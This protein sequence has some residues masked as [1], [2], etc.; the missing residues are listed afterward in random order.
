MTRRPLVA[1]ATVVAVL[2]IVAPA[3]A[4]WVWPVS[5]EVITPYHNGDDPYAA[6]QH[7]GI[8][9]AAAL[10]TSVVAAAG[11]EVRFA[12]TAGSS[13][14]TVSIRTADGRF[15]TSYLHLASTAVR[16]GQLVSAGERVGSVG[17]TGVRSAERPHLHFGVREAGSKD[18]YHDPLTFLPPP[19]LAPE[20][21]RSTPSPSPVPEPLTPG[22]GRAPAARR[23][24]AARPTPRRVPAARPTPRRVP[25]ARPA[26][27]PRVAPRRAPDGAPR[28]LPLPRSAPHATARRLPLPR[29]AAAAPGRRPSPS[30]LPAPAPPAAPVPSGALTRGGAAARGG[31]PTGGGAP[32]RGPARAPSSS[33]PDLGYA[34]ACLGLLVAAALLGLSEDGRQATRRSRDRVA[35]ALRPLMGRR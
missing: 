23:V 11:G 13:G 6:G 18:A 27:N 1:V 12:G 21:P 2:A 7:R 26:P 15:D 10:G 19:T 17:T 16:K 31:A 35:G 3:R 30:T 24:P 32:A 8:D 4:D 14:V 34:L 9:I 29:S 33:G 25:A 5:G 22:P 20:P 28:R